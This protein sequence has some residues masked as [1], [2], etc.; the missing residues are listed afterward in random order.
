MNKLVILS[1]LIPTI[2]AFL[3]DPQFIDTQQQLI[4]MF[5]CDFYNNMYDMEFPINDMHVDINVNNSN[6]A[7]YITITG[8][9]DDMNRKYKFGITNVCPD[10]Y[11]KFICSGNMCMSDIFYSIKIDST[12]P[13]L[14]KM[15]DYVLT[16]DKPHHK[17]FI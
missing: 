5:D 13:N 3:L 6:H 11:N 9:Q 14:N 2:S 12:L 16:L 10:M 8:E 15:L 7:I 17:F 1:I 4:T